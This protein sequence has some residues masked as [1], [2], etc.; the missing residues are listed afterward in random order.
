LSLAALDKAAQQLAEAVAGT[1]R[2]LDSS[3]AIR[4]EAGFIVDR[5]RMDR[6][7]RG[8]LVA[9]GSSMVATSSPRL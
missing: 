6:A 8:A 1:R 9:T 2:A 7:I 4:R 3:D 5:L